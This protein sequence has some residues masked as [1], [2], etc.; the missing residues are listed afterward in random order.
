[1]E[2]TATNL[3]VQALA[4]FAGAHCAAAALQ[5][6]RFGCCRSPMTLQRDL[7][8]ARIPESAGT[9]HHAVFW[10]EQSPPDKASLARRTTRAVCSRLDF[11]NPISPWLDETASI[12]NIFWRAGCVPKGACFGERR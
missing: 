8:R 12:C 7:K 5:D 1:M 2:W 3:I 4:G 10:T 6:H 9:R 11:Y